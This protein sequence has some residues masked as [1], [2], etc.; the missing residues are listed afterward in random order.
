MY[1]IYSRTVKFLFVC[2][3]FYFFLLYIFVTFSLHIQYTNT[4]LNA[5]LTGERFG[6]WGVW[7]NGPI[8]A[9]SVLTLFKLQN[10]MISARSP[11]RPRNLYNVYCS[12]AL[13]FSGTEIR[14]L[15]GSISYRHM[16]GNRERIPGLC[17][18]YVSG[19]P[20]VYVQICTHMLR[21]KLRKPH[22]HSSCEILKAF[23]CWLLL[24]MSSLV[25]GLELYAG[26]GISGFGMWQFLVRVY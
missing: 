25:L 11:L 7:R 24:G 17:K 2:S 1:L 16:A 13:R 22:T 9:E 15:S 18:T 26:G 3:F 19:L 23:H 6:L 5:E 21:A 20:Y 10:V 14:R 4:E 8:R 12:R